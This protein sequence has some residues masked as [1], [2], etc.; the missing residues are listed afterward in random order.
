MA[1]SEDGA[2]IVYC[3]MTGCDVNYEKL[4]PNG[5]P[6]VVKVSLTLKQVVQYPGTEKSIQFVGFDTLKKARE[7]FDGNPNRYGA[8][9]KDISTDVTNSLLSRAGLPLL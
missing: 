4:F 8:A 5:Q 7:T 2:D 9:P 6:K 1:L 3:V